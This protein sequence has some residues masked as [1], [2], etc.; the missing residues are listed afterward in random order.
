[1]TNEFVTVVNRTSKVLHGTWDGKPYDIAP[2]ENHLPRIVAIAARYQNPIM[3]K[4]TPLEDW[5]IKSEYLLGIVEDGDPIDPIEQTA[6]P[7]R[8]DSNLVNGPNVEVVRARASFAPSAV[9]RLAATSPGE[10][11]IAN[12]D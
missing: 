9:D 7:Q 12:K 3:G 1:M 10:G 6:A 8:W 2:G 4:G 11:F 5:S